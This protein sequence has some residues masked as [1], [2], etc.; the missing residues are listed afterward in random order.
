MESSPKT[1]RRL[2]VTLAMV[3]VVSPVAAIPAVAGQ[4]QTCV[5]TLS[6][7]D[8]VGLN[9]LDF[10]LDYSNAN[11][12]IE[13]SGA[14]AVCRR[15][16]GGSAMAAFKD[17]DAAQKLALAIMRSQPLFSG[18]VVL[19][20]CRF[21]YDTSVP[22]LADFQVSVEVAAKGGDDANVEPLPEV[23]VTKIECPGELPQPDTTTSTTTTTLV[24][25]GRCGFPVSDGEI[26]LA[27]DALYV[28][29]AAVGLEPCA[30]C[31]CDVDGSSLVTATDALLV[32]KAAVGGDALL[33]CPA[34]S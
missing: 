34:C 17:D 22:A 23:R 2:L 31:V 11:G 29:H 7:I 32:L 4:D 27:S 3:A 19:A 18:P 6:L 21:N 8:Q 10:K 30:K 24:A 16:L 13:G 28:L 12:Q 9:N 20:G 15:A 33:A 25:G 26:P 1:L 14:G 5:I